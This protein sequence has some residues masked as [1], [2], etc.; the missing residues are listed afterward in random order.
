MHCALLR[1]L[2]A[3]T[4]KSIFVGMISDFDIVV[5]YLH[6]QVRKIPSPICVHY[7]TRAVGY[8][9]HGRSKKIHSS[10]CALSYK[11]VCSHLKMHLHGD[12]WSFGWIGGVFALKKIPPQYAQ[13]AF[14]YKFD[15]NS[16]YAIIP[17]AFL[18]R[19]EW[20]VFA[21]WQIVKLLSPICAFSDNKPTHSAVT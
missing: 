5:G 18:H 11:P 13:C 19:L 3:V 10:I 8:L 20:G 21:Y 4:C 15:C 2:S 1:S 6:W 16:L 12:N 9:H 7:F 17:G 14:S